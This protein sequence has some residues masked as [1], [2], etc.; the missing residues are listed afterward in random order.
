MSRFLSLILLLACLSLTVWF[1]QS[2]RNLNKDVGA[3]VD[4]LSRFTITGG[5]GRI[6]K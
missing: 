6:D 5:H 4:H 2:T 1:L 3:F